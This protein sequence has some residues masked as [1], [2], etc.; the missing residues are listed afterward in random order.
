MTLKLALLDQHNHI[1]GFITDMKIAEIN[2]HIDN[3]CVIKMV[4]I[5]DQ[6][7]KT[8]KDSMIEQFQAMGKYEIEIHEQNDGELVYVWDTEDKT[9]QYFEFD[10]EGNL[11]DMY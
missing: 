2:T 5:K 1:I 3:G 8:F 7:E 6:E 10:N 11:V 4:E 9:S